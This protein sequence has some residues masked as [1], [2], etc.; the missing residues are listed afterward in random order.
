MYSIDFSLTNG[1][2]KPSISVYYSG[3]DIPVK[4]K[5]C[6][7]EELWLNKKSLLGYEELLKKVNWYKNFNYKKELIVTFLGGDPLAPYNRNSVMEVSRKL[8]EDFPEIQLILY[9]WRNPDEID[10]EWV[11]HF[12]YG[13]LGKFDIDNYNENYLPGSS[14]QIIYDFKTENVLK[15]I[16]LK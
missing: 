14:N 11:K 8:K 2:G 16:K 5:G 13:V 3:C 9:S 6:H 7:N 15:S 4:C 12:D 1:L 10:K